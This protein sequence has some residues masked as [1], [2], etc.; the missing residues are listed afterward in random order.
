MI[1]SSSRTVAKLRFID[2]LI[3]RA[4]RHQFFVS[5]H[6]GH[7]A[8]VDGDRQVAER[9]PAPLELAFEA[10]L[11]EQRSVHAPDVLRAG[12]ELRV[13]VAEPV[14]IEGLVGPGIRRG[15]GA[16]LPGVPGLDAQVSNATGPPGMLVR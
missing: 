14:E 13:E 10:H 7:P 6:V 8:P 1:H 9:E 12:D 3:D 11:V 16:V 4:A 2:L 5:A 15:W